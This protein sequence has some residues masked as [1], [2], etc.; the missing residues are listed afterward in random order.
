[1]SDVISNTVQGWGGKH[2]ISA[3]ASLHRG[4]APDDGGYGRG[5]TP[6]C[7]AKYGLASPDLI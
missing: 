5:C 7:F 2:P 6:S 4:L 1:V 3:E